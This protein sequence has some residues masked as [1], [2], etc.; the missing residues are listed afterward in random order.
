MKY[1]LMIF[2]FL[3]F[4]ISAH[5]Q[6]TKG[7]SVP[8]TAENNVTGKTHALIVGVAKYRNS[9]IPSLKY[10]D[11][12]AVEFY[13]YL[14]ACGVDTV[15]MQLLLNEN[16]K[17]SEIMLSVSDLTE[18]A[19]KGDKVFIYFSGHGDVE[20]KVITNDGY[21]LPYDAPKAV[22][23]I[24]AINVNIL[25]T[26]ISTLSSHGVQVIVITDA[27]HS[28]NLAGGLEGLKNIS[29][30]LKS[31]WKDEV[32]ILSC[33]PGELSLEGKQW[34]AG[35]GLFSYELINGMAGAADINNDGI[36]TLQELNRFMTNTVADE[37]NPNSQNPVL[38]GD[39]GLTIST[40]N[41]DYLKK[42]TSNTNNQMIAAVDLKG[43]DESIL[44]GLDDSVRYNYKM[45]KAAMDTGNY[46]TLSAHAD[47][48]F[49]TKYLQPCA[50]SYYLKIP[51]NEKTHLIVGIMKRN[52]CSAM[53]S[54][55]ENLIERFINYD[56]DENFTRN[57]VMKT[58]SA[59][60]I[61]RAILGDKKAISLEF[62]PKLLALEVLGFGIGNDTGGSYFLKYNCFLK[63]DSA[64]QMAPNAGYLYMLRGTYRNK[65]DSISIHDL[66]MAINLSPKMV[67]SYLSLNL[68]YFQNKKYNECISL[69]NE[70]KKMNEYYYS[71][72]MLYD[73]YFEMKNYDS[74]NYY[75][76][77][78][79][80]IA[81]TTSNKSNKSSIYESV[82]NKLYDLKEYDSSNFY[83]LKVYSHDSIN[84]DPILNLKI[85]KNYLHQKNY[86]EAEKYLNKEL[87]NPQHNP[88]V[89]YNISCCYAIKG[90]KENA[91]NYL[92]KGLKKNN[93]II[94]Y[95]LIREN[96]D[97]D[98]IR[99][100]PEFK[101]LMKKYFPNDYKE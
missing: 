32:K 54:D 29:N 72:G 33:Q 78:L 56:F 93:S 100:T 9:A 1:A 17:Y 65:Y 58:C 43:F 7:F 37:A 101:A 98:N 81:D 18:K 69:A 11:K 20:S 99:P 21:L 80:K 38:S 75:K 16:A 86:T 63:L 34:G 5:S 57:N 44:A 49:D 94:N 19:V 13:S 61:C 4:A 71:S 60:E 42:Y 6:N 95:T 74:A 22:Y 85:A 39:M 83:Y 28:G 8:K 45:F 35:R 15:N 87:L 41:K 66:R 73:V 64:I 36:V 59:M 24:S 53:M 89:Y 96:P 26:Y 23:A 47:M 27:C 31:Q 55:G 50:Y 12:D 76:N 84:D 70:L 90:D 51:D 92:E 46:L 77:I 25:Q 79:L 68:I 62:M 91:M 82:A 48:P 3:L 2:A 40:V 52:L 10:A 67:L 88:W 14:K 97:L 30:V